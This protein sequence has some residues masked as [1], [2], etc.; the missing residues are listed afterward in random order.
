MYRSRYQALTLIEVLAATVLLS[1]VLVGVVL[2]RGRATTQWAAAN[3]LLDTSDLA[4]AWLTAHW[5]DLEN[6][7]RDENGV[8][9]EGKNLRWRTQT[10]TNEAVEALGSACVRFEVFE[11]Q[12]SIDEAAILSIDLVLPGE[13]D[14]AGMSLGI[15]GDQP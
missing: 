8:L 13:K 1:L 4:D 5:T 6:F 9:D 10:I 15:S 11:G 14:D 7:P 3:R 2:A 12:S